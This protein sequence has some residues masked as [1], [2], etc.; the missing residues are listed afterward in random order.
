MGARSSSTLREVRE[1]GKKLKWI[2]D[3][4]A[5]WGRPGGRGEREGNRSNDNRPAGNPHL[6]SQGSGE[7][8]ATHPRRTHFPQT[9][10][11]GASIYQL[12]KHRSMRIVLYSVFCVWMGGSCRRK[13]R[14]GR[15]TRPAHRGKDAGGLQFFRRSGQ[16]RCWLRIRGGIIDIENRSIGRRSFS[17]KKNLSQGR[18][19]RGAALEQPLSGP[20]G[21]GLTHRARCTIK[22][23]KGGP[24]GIMLGK[25]SREAADVPKERLKK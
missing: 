1:G 2:N 15:R 3:R 9:E 13:E 11:K 21:I 17:A 22:T 19:Y 8:Q 24:S 16:I 10:R 5:Q 20:G 12:N 7:K 18:H 23:R 4:V 25:G 6:P 14:R